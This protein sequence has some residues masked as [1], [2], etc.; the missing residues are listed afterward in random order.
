MKFNT[1]DHGNKGD[2]MAARHIAIYG[3]GGG[4]ASAVAANVSAALAEEG[5]RVIMIGC[6]PQ[7]DATVTLRG[8]REISTVLDVLRLNDSA[9]MDD[10]AV[11]GF[12]GVLCIEAFSLFR[13]E[14]CA[15]RSIAR[16][17]SFFNKVG[18][19][20]EYRPDVVFY[21]LPAEVICG[22]FT[23]PSGDTVFDLAYVVSSS[24]FASIFTTN[25][26]F[27]AIRKYADSGGPRLGGIIANALT[28]PFAES[29]VKDYA[30]RTGTRVTTCLPHSSV[31]VQSELYG[32]TV[33]EAGPQ[34]NHAY[35]Y[36][37]LAGKIIGN[38]NTDIPNPLTAREL[39]N[40]AR[41][42]GDWM[43]ELEL[44]VIRDGE[45]I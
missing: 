27:R 43:Y 2:S 45:A 1:R 29:I 18:L 26:I 3:N 15:G 21:V 6:D 34:S 16:V 36:R 25:N 23:L 38:Q 42:W 17:F 37:R 39:R 28:A 4:G 41:G 7:N 44:G 10:F 9:G 24:D 13:S 20:D 8:D 30:G 33:I 19:F 22:A 5:H 40:W 32:Q 31:V 35:M 14:E 12:K 11:T